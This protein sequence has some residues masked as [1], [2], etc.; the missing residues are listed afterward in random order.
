V[1]S[2][3]PDSKVLEWIDIDPMSEEHRNFVSPLDQACAQNLD[4]ID[5]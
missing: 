1:G 4:G 5:T 2:D 3:S